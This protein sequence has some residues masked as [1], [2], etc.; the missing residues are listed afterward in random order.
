MTNQEKGYTEEIAIMGGQPGEC[1]YE[2]TVNICSFLL[3]KK[4]G[5]AGG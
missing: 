4:T 1:K 2:T 3:V 5:E